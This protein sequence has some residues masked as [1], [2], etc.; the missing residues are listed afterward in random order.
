M[1]GPAAADSRNS[2]DSSRGLSLPSRSTFPMA[3]LEVNDMPQ[4]FT[5]MSAHL[6]CI[7]SGHIA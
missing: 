1:L 2:L 5:D 6:A 7:G 4:T 3:R